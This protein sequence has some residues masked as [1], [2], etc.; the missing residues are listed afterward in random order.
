MGDGGD[1][2]GGIAVECDKH[3]LG[4]G[5]AKSCSPPPPPRDACTGRNY[6]RLRIS[7]KVLFKV[8]SSCHLHAPS[9]RPPPALAACSQEKRKRV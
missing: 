7:S 3:T 8:T 5:H 2:Q 4:S 6:A 9:P 1:A